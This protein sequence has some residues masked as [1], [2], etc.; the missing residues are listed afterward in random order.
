MGRIRRFLLRKLRGVAQEEVETASE[1]A[2]RELRG[3]RDEL[4]FVKKDRLGVVEQRGIV[5]MDMRL[6]VSLLERA[7][8]PEGELF[9]GSMAYLRGRAALYDRVAGEVQSISAGWRLMVEA[10]TSRS[11]SG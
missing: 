11:S 7:S 5:S 3:L 6:A 4:A 10:D 1:R 2:E 9:E 8:L